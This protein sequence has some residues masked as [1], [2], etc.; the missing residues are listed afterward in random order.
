MSDTIKSVSHP[1]VHGMVALNSDGTRIDGL[2]SLPTAG[3][4]GSSVY[5]GFS[6]VGDDLTQTKTINSVNYQRT[7]T[8]TGSGPYT[9]TIS[10]WSVI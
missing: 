2:D 8:W 5:V 7:F 6:T 3:N 10:A 9:L 4:N 1:L